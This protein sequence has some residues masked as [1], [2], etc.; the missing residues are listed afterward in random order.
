VS[1]VISKM[2][3]GGCGAADAARVAFTGSVLGKSSHVLLAMGERLNAV[4]PEIAVDE[5][6]VRPLEGALWRARGVA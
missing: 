5:A 3:A 4:W 2:R 1:L 6:A